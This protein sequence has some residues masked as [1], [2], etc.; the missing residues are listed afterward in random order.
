MQK[1]QWHT[2]QKRV[3]DLVPQEINPRIITDKQMSD[4]KKSLKKYNLVEIPAIDFNGKI[5]A[6]HQ[7]VKALQLLNRGEDVIDVRKPNRQLT[8][9][10]AK[11]YLIASNSLGGDWDFESLKSFDLDILMEAGFDQ[12]Q[13]AKFW[14]E[15]KEVVDDSFNIEKEI[16]KITIP[17]TKLGDIIHLGCHKLICGDSTKPETI[18]RLFGEEK[19]SMIYSDPVYNLEINYGAG[20]GGNRDYGGNVNDSRSF[21]EYKT[22][23]KDSLKTALSTTIPDVH[24]F[25]WCD[26]IYIGLIQ[27]VYR[28]L[29]INNKR[30]CL[31]LKN[32]QNPVPTVA[33]NKVYEPVVYGVR[34]KP[35]LAESITNLNEVMNK[36]FGTGND[37]LTQVDNFVDV[38]TAKRLSAKDYE[39]ATSKPPRLHEKAIKR[40]T[41]PGD[42]I[43]DSFL[44]SGSTLLAG[45]QLGRRV[46]GCDLEPRFCD[47]IVKR[48]EAF[49]GNKAIYEKE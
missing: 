3:N 49:T 37:L 22:F 30:V 19:A 11:Q 12:I 36:E 9:K 14:D 27:E 15:E 28:S 16:K 21:E 25:Y 24:V 34:G 43:L 35:Y 29:G 2:V 47:L 42:I 17:K 4:L 39:H 18:K 23:I 10:E 5:L 7:R 8:E 20:I 44:G 26:Q 45:E 48:Y 1:L 13:L 41:K 32:N 6:G 38:W 40:C 31:W 46:Y 33:F